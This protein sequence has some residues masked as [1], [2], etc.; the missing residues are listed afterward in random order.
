MD[1][2]IELESR[3]IRAAIVVSRKEDG[4]WYGEILEMGNTPTVR[5]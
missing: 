4:N 1:L 3:E 2:K 5:Q